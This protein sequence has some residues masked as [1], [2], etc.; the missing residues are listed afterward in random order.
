[1]ECPT[2]ADSFSTLALK[3]KVAILFATRRAN[4]LKIKFFTFAH[5]IMLPRSKVIV[6]IYEMLDFLFEN[7]KF[8]LIKAPDSA[9]C[10]F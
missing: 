4:F 1:L 3:E 9:I 10:L 5:L 2:Q 7:S 6:D 8:L